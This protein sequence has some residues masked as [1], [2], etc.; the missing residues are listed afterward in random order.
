MELDEHQ[1]EMFWSTLL[2]DL[3]AHSLSSINVTI[4]ATNRPGDERHIIGRCS[5]LTNSLDRVA[6]KL[7]SLTIDFS[8]DPQY[9]HTPC[10]ERLMPK[11]TLQPFSH[12][13]FL[14]LAEHTLVDRGFGEPGYDG[15]RKRD[16]SVVLPPSLESLTI[17]CPGPL[18]ITWLGDLFEICHVFPRLRVIELIYR[19][20]SGCRPP[21]LET[22]ME[23]LVQAFGD[24]GVQVLIKKDVHSFYL[25]RED[26]VFTKQELIWQRKEIVN[27]S[28]L[29]SRHAK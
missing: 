15:S 5:V 16:L 10:I 21:W 29:A 23:T 22:E 17:T 6:P 18:T 11:M 7:E 24:K 13:R 12:L 14:K 28:D 4:I 20:Y 1:P 27:W 2:L 3:Q 9:V 8:P 19:P 26:R 25:A